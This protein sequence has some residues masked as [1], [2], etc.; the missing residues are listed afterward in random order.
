MEHVVEFWRE[1]EAAHDEDPAEPDIDLDR[2]DMAR[3]NAEDLQEYANEHDNSDVARS[4]EAVRQCLTMGPSSP[5]PIEA[6]GEIY[7]VEVFRGQSKE[8]F[9]GPKKVRALHVR[10]GSKLGKIVFSAYDA[11]SDE[12]L[13]EECGLCVGDIQG[14]TVAKMI[15]HVSSE[16]RDVEIREVGKVNRP[17]RD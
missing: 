10:V 2:R 5:A 14:A 9:G 7:E 8:I 16:T 13:L 15:E 1:V 6:L 3:F 17:D 11:D 12:W 4:E